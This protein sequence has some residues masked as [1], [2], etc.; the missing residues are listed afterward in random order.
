MA[1]L[2]MLVLELNLLP[3]RR[4]AEVGEADRAVSGGALI[5]LVFMHKHNVAHRDACTRN[6]VMDVS[7]AVP[8]GSHF[9]EWNTHDG[10]VKPV[11]YYFIDFG[12]HGSLGMPH[13]QI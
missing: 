10:A 5:G 6:L 4:V 12:T 8:K 11:K 3:F 1:I 7:R 13:W 9:I 2:V